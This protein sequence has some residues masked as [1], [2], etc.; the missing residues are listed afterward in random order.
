MLGDA[1]SNKVRLSFEHDI[2]GWFGIDEVLQKI[3]YHLH[4]EVFHY[5]K[6]NKLLS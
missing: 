2:Y 4:K 6:N 1:K 3:E 5:I